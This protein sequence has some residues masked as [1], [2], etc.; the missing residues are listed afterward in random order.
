MMIDFFDKLDAVEQ[1]YLSIEFELANNSSVLSD[2]KTYSDM[3]KEYNSLSPLV[4][5]YREY[6]RVSD[7]ID[8]AEKIISE[9]ED[10]DMKEMAQEELKLLKEQSSVLK[11]DIAIMLIPRDRKS[12]V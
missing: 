8:D 10:S 12:V 6:K 2:I 7:E 5:K 3:I 1:R 4:E 11:N 9:S